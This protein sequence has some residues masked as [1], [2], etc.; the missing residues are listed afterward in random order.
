MTILRADRLPPVRDCV[1]AVALVAC[2]GPVA[3]DSRGAESEL[4]S[5][6]QRFTKGGAE[7]CGGPSVE[8]DRIASGKEALQ[9]SL[10]CTAASAKKRHASWTYR[11]YQGVDSWLA[12]GLLATPE[13]EIYR[14]SFDSAPCG[15]PQCRGRFTIELCDRPVVVVTRSQIAGLACSPT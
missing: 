3:A 15:G 11:H 5:Y 2:N 7:D 10:G 9:A 1:L 14:F 6:V 12:E 8:K 13:G 4:R